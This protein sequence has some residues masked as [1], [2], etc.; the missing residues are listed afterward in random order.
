MLVLFA[1]SLTGLIGV[2]G[3]VID[4]GGAWSQSRSQQKVAD[5]AALAGAIKE[6]NG[7]LKPAIIQA[8]LDSAAA[9]GFA[10]SEVTVNIPPTTGKYTPGG[11]LSGALST[12][13]CS[14]AALSPCWIEVAVN[15]AHANSF[16]RVLGM[17]SFGVSARAV[18]VGGVANA[19]SNGVAPIM[20][21]YKSVKKFGSTE[22]TFCDPEPSKCADNSAWP[23]DQ[24]QA[25]FAWT[26]FCTTSVDCNV[27]SSTAKSII[28]GG[29]FQFQVSL[30]MYLGPHNQGQKTDVCH[31]LLDQFPNGADLSVAINDDNGNL[32]GW[33][34]WHLDT[35]N[36]DCEGADGEQLAGWFVSDATSS[37]PLTIVAGGGKATFGEQVVRLVE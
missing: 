6:A 28:A 25:Q 9:N 32:V 20:F 24:N 29:N 16:S 21:N 12:N 27:D 19:V 18:S 13:D 23:T 3:L 15:R 14:T 8:A 34:V 10:A 36:S 22:T 31:K 4:L 1:L 11:A 30:A 5:T 33:W 2:A 37:L 26:T 35:A 7:A 17:S